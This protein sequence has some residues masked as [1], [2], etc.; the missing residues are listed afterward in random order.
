M[1]ETEFEIDRDS[2]EQY[3]RMQQSLLLL[4][5]IY[6]CGIGLV[7][8]YLHYYKY[9]KFSRWFCPQ[10][11]NNLRYWLEGN[12]LRADSGV[13]F[14]WRKSIPLERITDV[15]LFQGPLMRHCGIWT[16]R[17]QTAGSATCEA[18]LYGI[19]E[20]ERIRELIL[21]KR[22]NINGEKSEDA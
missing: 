19:R 22:K 6:F 9:N 10:Q 3:W 11:V 17:I 21:S 18:I 15:V 1:Q 8:A 4:S 13:F 5:F 12:T 16:M 7:L 14:L 20:P 2:V